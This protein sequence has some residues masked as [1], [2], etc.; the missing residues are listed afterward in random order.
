MRLSSSRVGVD[1]RVEHLIAVGLR[2]GMGFDRSDLRQTEALAEAMRMTDFP[3]LLQLGRATIRA[4][5]P[6]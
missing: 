5:L 3:F 1:L 4:A 2:N 6:R